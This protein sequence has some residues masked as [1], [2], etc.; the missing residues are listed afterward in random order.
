MASAFDSVLERARADPSEVL[1]RRLFTDT[2]VAMCLLAADD[3]ADCRSNLAT[4]KAL[5]Q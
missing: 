3:E 2:P 5:A 4:L 1:A